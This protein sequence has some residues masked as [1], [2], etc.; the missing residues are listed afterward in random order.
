MAG[1][2]GCDDASVCVGVSSHG[3]YPSIIFY[4][5]GGQKY[6]VLVCHCLDELV[7]VGRVVVFRAPQMI[8]GICLLDG[9]GRPLSLLVGIGSC[10]MLSVVAGR[11]QV[12]SNVGDCDCLW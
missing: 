6:S 2:G 5:G 4:V 7:C 8:V 12:M 10:P 1:G 9:R 3:P 11:S